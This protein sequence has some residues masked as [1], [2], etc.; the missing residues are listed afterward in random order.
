MSKKKNKYTPLINQFLGIKKEQPD[1]LL[2]FRMGDFYETFFDDAKRASRL[3]GIALTTRDKQ[4]K[5][6]VP[7]AGFPVKSLNTY[8]KKLLDNGIKVAICE[9]VEDPKKAKK[10]VKREIVEVITPGT[11]LE[12]NYLNNTN[13]NFLTAIFSVGSEW[14]VSSLDISTGEFKSTQN[15][16]KNLVDEIIK[17]HPTRL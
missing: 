3:L 1:A 6:Q 7:L 5:N 13:N 9:Q 11:I 8:L 14:G 12:E 4:R 15:P 10:L 2:L 17:I 16:K